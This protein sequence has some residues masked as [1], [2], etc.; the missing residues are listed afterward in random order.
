MTYTAAVSTPGSALGSVL[1][2][3]A[4]LVA[5]A[6]LTVA[7]AWRAVR[8]F[9]VRRGIAAGLRAAD[10]DVRSAAVHQAA[11]LGLA[12]TAPALLRAVRAETDPAVLAE[13]VRTVAARQWEPASTGRIV[14]LRLWAK[15]YAEH[16]AELLGATPTDPPLLPGV[17]GAVPPP[18]LDPARAAEFRTRTDQVSLE[19]AAAEVAPA[20]ATV[21]AVAPDPDPLSPVRVLVTG[22]GGPAGVAVIRAL[23][24]RGHHVIAVDADPSA[25]G[26]RLADQQFVVPRFDD[27]HY[28]AALLRVATLAQ[29]VAL[30]CTV[31]EEYPSL[32]SAV[33]Y[34][35]EAG[36]R[37]FLPSV[38]SVR[39]CLDKWRF[40]TVLL[41]SGLPAP[42]T[43]L[44]TDPGVADLPGPWVV[45]PRYGRGSR[46]VVNCRTRRQLGDALRRVADPIVQTRLAGREFTADALVDR[47]GSVAG[48]AARWR[49]ET[50]GGISVKGTTFGH[51]EV[52]SVVALV[53]KS[54]GLVGPANVQGFVADDGSVAVHEVN[55]RFSGGLPLSLAA[56]ADLVEEYLRAILGRAVRPERLVARPDVTMLRY[57]CEVFEG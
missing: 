50:R 22:A 11:E 16:H 35:D 46:D 6:A 52:H 54:V 15:V 12:S 40:A 17:P 14:E 8:L 43:A 21:A 51:D 27:P 42:V 34:L 2:S 7:V 23:R 9:R 24:S 48:I 39:A 55:P 18:S 45:K 56:G 20:A 1:G 19:D 25:V 3:G 4:L 57:F 10:P 28:L 29:T 26:L 38:D 36:I 47:S 41:E 5:L 32:S 30:V 33:D 37:T 13:V 49:T 31:A 53:L 44:G